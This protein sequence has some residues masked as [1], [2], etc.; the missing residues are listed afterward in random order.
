MW[1]ESPQSWPTTT[2][3]LVN[4]MTCPRRDGGRAETPFGA[5]VRARTDLDS[6][7]H[8]LDVCDGDW[9]FH[10][11][12]THDGKHGTRSV[13]QMMLVEVKTFSR[14]PPP[15]QLETL[16]FWHQLTFNRRPGETRLRGLADRPAVNVWCHGVFVLQ[17]EADTPE[18]GVIRWHSFSPDGRLVE[19][20][21]ASQDHL[22]H[23]LG[24]RVRPNEP[25]RQLSVRAHHFSEEVTVKRTLPLGFTIDETFTRRS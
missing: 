22:A 11:Y 25:S 8:W 14:M 19:Y 21:L 10:A 12:K 24:F 20:E 9:I 13:R 1:T 3:F 18:S 17:L 7:T 4:D 16:W 6:Q 5:W 23:V 2:A 15:N